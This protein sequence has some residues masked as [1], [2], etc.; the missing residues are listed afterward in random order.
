MG[1]EEGF[2]QFKCG[3]SNTASRVPALAAV[4][5]RQSGDLQGSEARK[6]PGYARPAGGFSAHTPPPLRTNNAGLG[7]T[8]QATPTAQVALDG[9]A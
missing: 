5:V 9:G 7:Q 2:G 6:G 4:S 3:L 1:I 8:T